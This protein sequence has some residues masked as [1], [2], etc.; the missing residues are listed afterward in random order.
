MGV[1]DRS[2]LIDAAVNHAIDLVHYSN[3]VVRR[4]RALMRNVDTDLT[5]KLTIALQDFDP[6][7]F[8]VRRLRE[9]LAGLRTTDLD[10]QARL[11]GEITPELRN[12][13]EYEA[14]Y[15]RQLFGNSI[16]APS[17]DQLYAAVTSK[18]FQGK[19]LSEWFEGLIGTRQRRLENAIAVGFTEGRTI[20]EIVRTV[21]GR[22]DQNFKDG[23]LEISR[24]DA[25]SV[26]RTAISHTAATVR[27]EMY[28]RNTDLLEAEE[29]VS[30]LDTRTTPTCQIRDGLE[31]ST[32]D[33]EPI[34]HKVPWGAGP[35]RIHWGCRST[36]VPILK[37]DILGI[38]SKSQRAA[39]GGPVS[40]GT[41]YGSWLKRQSAERQDEILGPTRGM[42]MRKGGVTFDRFFNNEGRYLTIDQLRKRDAAAFAKANL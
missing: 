22:R 25:E 16:R 23:I 29:W 3:D 37:K 33:H 19:L 14:G 10:M 18:P 21:R 9:L 39:E 11:T 35:G 26:V 17:Q 5:T 20:D 1:N 15:Q 38:T 32:V 31:Y 41:K 4:I 8:T 42:L 30:T 27:E 24:R 12:L 40:S 13:A 2:Y 6:D 28:S 36:S 34:G 7:S